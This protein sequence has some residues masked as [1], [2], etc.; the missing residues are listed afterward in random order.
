M[1]VYVV[2]MQELKNGKVEYE[3]YYFGY[4][5]DSNIANRY[6][7]QLIDKDEDTYVHSEIYSNMYFIQKMSESKFA[8]F[9]ATNHLTIDL[10]EDYMGLCMTESD[11][12]NYMDT[13]MDDFNYITDLLKYGKDITVV[14]DAICNFSKILKSKKLRKNAKI[15][16]L[17]I[18]YMQSFFEDYESIEHEIDW[19]KV[20]RRL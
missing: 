2:G 8:E 3:P 18:N 17:V 1:L 10:I 19:K 12:A 11:Y 9:K 6:Y 20:H 5:Y 7:Q 14:T 4:T 16:K 15:L 13:I